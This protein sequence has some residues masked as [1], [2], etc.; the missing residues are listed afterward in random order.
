MMNGYHKKNEIQIK[1]FRN[2]PNSKMVYCNV[3][4]FYENLNR[5]EMLYS[6]RIL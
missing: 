4:Y 3:E 6:E 5:I 1:K 2:N